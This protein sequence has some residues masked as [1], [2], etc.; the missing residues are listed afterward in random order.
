MVVWSGDLPSPLMAIFL[1][2]I[3]FI[4]EKD[5]EGPVGVSHARGTSLTFFVI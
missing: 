2:W 4:F 1:Q 3:A 5:E